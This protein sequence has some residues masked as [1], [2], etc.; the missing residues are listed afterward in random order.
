MKI[1]GLIEED[2]V[3]YKNP[4]MFI[5]TCYCSFKCEKECGKQVCQNSPLIKEQVME[6]DDDALI[7][8]YLKNPITKSIVFGGLEPFEQFG[9]LVSFIYKLRQKTNDTVV[10]YSGFLKSEIMEQVNVLNQFPNIIIKF[11][12]YIPNDTP[13]YDPILGVYLASQNQYAEKIS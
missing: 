7:D 5:Q 12:R 13:R 8:R 3:N 2:F 6:I 4:S 9:E 10:I 1:K 11:G